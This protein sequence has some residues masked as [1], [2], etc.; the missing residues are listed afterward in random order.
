MTSVAY[1]DSQLLAQD[2]FTLLQSIDPSRSRT[3]LEGA[4]RDKLRELEG[5]ARSAI[6]QLSA[7]ADEKQ[8]RLGAELGTLAGVLASPPSESF[9]AGLASWEPFRKRLHTAYEDLSSVLLAEAIALP[10]HRPTNYTRSLFHVLMGLGSVALVQHVLTPRSMIMV[11]AAFA[12]WAWSMEIGRRF[13]TRLNELLM[14]AF[15]QVAHEHERRKVN[16]ST[17]YTTALLILALT[18]SPRTCAI[19]LVVLAV[20]DPAAALVGR[21]WGKTKLVAGRSLEGTSTFVVVGALTTIAMLR[22]YYP[23]LPMGVTA[24]LACAAALAGAISEVVSKRIDDNLTIPLAAAAAAGVVGLS[25]GL[26]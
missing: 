10:T 4:I 3:Q 18:S 6:A 25:L 23:E 12:G 17:W 8:A 20:G 5:R 19:A 13:S 22:L 9:D 24:A 11:T 21:R 16:S 2:L 15:K 7:E 14:I 26:S 1:Q